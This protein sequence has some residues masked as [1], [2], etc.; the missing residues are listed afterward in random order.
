MPYV[1]EKIKLS[2]KQDRRVKLTQNQKE[3]IRKLY[4]TGEYSHR[5]L[6]EKYSVSR[7]LIQIIVNPESERR[8][9]EYSK[10]N[11]HKYKDK[12]KHRETIKKTRKYKYEL[13]KNG[14]L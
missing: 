11:W 3:E 1:C 4:S 14:E 5:K 6:A 13:Y 10:A 8:M 9:K 7:R 12:D 2:E